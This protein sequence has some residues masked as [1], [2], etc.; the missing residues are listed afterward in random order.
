MKISASIKKLE[1]IKPFRIARGEKVFVE[2]VFVCVESDGITGH[3]EASPNN[4]Y[5]ETAQDVLHKFS[6]L[7]NFLSD[8]KTTSIQDIKNIWNQ[9]WPL[10]QPSR[11]TQCA[12]DLALW[13]LLGK[14]RGVPVSR[15]VW[16]KDP[17]PLTSSCTLSISDP[18]GWETQAALVQNCPII[19]IKMDQ[20][21][22]V[23]FTKYISSVTTGIIRVDANCSWGNVD[24]PSIVRLLQPLRVELVEQPLPPDSDAFMRTILPHCV[25]PMLADESCTIAPCVES[26]QHTFSGI[27]IKLVKCGG[28]TP[29]IEMLTTAKKLGLTV[30]V[31]CMLESNL[32][33]AAGAALAQQADYVDLDGSWLLKGKIFSGVDFTA[34]VLKLSGNYGLGVS[35]L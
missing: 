2:N 1:T 23:G 22:D 18:S 27:N 20:R 17:L 30:M 16:N 14:T 8:R 5:H 29:G 11:A 15:L 12:L 7:D 3:G 4:Y 25:L 19:K 35:P 31:G 32:L 9:V 6:S 24:I 10:V 21:A 28:L 26:L 13:D 34:G 33:I